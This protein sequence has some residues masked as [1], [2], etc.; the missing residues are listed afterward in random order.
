MA[1]RLTAAQAAQLQRR[2]ANAGN[3][4]ASSYQRIQQ[5]IRAQA[6]NLLISGRRFESFDQIRQRH[7]WSC[8]YFATDAN[9]YLSGVQQ[10]F[11]TPPGQVGQGFPVALTERETNWKSANRVPDNQNFEIT[12]L[13]LTVGVVPANV[14]SLGIVP[15]GIQCANFLQNCVVYITYLTNSVPL[16]MA[17]DFGQASA[18]YGGTYR[19]TESTATTMEGTVVSN[20]LPAPGLR[21]RLKVPILLQ[22]GETFSF[23]LE[24]PRAVWNGGE[25][26]DIYT[27]F[28]FWATESFAER[29]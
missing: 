14:G 21:R 26:N 27:R 9:G 25:G 3:G 15:P 28:D 5:S 11:I 7:F 12:E 4:G 10:L 19:V 2:Q 17:T 22:H 8:A 29:S 13:G 16:G 23:T 20:G 1:N 18:P 6:Q 24:L